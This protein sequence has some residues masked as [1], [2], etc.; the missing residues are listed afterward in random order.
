MGFRG[1]GV[2]GLREG[3]FELS[4]LWFEVFRLWWVMTSSRLLSPQDPGSSVKIIH[5]K[6][7]DGA[8]CALR[9]GKSFG[10][11]QQV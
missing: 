6:V 4:G 5:A 8:T 2:L 10:R 11:P 7:H 9:K 3:L 1:L